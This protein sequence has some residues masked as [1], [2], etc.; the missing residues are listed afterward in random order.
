MEN[1]EMTD[2]EVSKDPIVRENNSFSF[3]EQWTVSEGGYFPTDKTLLSLPHGYY[4]A[5]HSNAFGWGFVKKEVLTDKLLVMPDSPINEIMDDVRRFWKNKDI[6]KKYEYVYKRGILLYG[7]PGCG[8]SSIISLLCEELINEHSG[9]IINIEH[10]ELISG[11]IEALNKFRA[12]EK[13]RNIIVLLED[14]DN[15]EDYAKSYMTELLNLLDGNL[16]IDNTVFIATTNYPD[17]LAE[18]ITNR[19]SRFDRRYDVGL[20]TPNDRLFYINNILD[21]DDIKSLDLDKII[22]DTEGFSIDHLKELVLSIFVLRKE[23]VNAL[24]E[25]KEIANGK[26]LKTS[27]LNKTQ[28]G[29]KG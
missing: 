28:V 26:F 7:A 5:Q 8:K 6:Y 18:R 23:Y 10:P 14:I 9:I 13:G 1:T 29:Y 21:N 4:K 3:Y 24:R 22:K 2:Q 12:I 15:F 25:I 20:P 11:S 19:P 16:K 27:K 17:K